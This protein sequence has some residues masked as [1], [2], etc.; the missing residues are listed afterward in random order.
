MKIRFLMLAMDDVLFSNNNNNL[1][2]SLIVVTSEYHTSFYRS[3]QNI[4]GKKFKNHKTNLDTLVKY[5]VN[6]FYNVSY[7][8][9]KQE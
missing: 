6:E 8:E 5:T 4:T 1:I 3:E 2:F 7:L 9:C